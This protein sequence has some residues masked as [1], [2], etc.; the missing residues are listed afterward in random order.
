MEPLGSFTNDSKINGQEG[1]LL[2]FFGARSCD[3]RS[4][5]LKKHLLHRVLGSCGF[6]RLVHVVLYIILG[7]YFGMITI[8]WYENLLLFTF[9]AGILRKKNCFGPIRNLLSFS[10]AQTNENA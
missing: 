10:T 9:L 2:K 5:M 8:F 3:H 6:V 7:R 1:H 4:F